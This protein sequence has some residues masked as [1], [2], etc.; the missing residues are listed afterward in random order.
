MLI[1]F[2][3]ADQSACDLTKKTDVNSVLLF[4]ITLNECTLRNKSH[5]KLLYLL[6]VSNYSWYLEVI[7]TSVSDCSQFSCYNI[8]NLLSARVGF[9]LQFTK[10]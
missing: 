9:F 3:I 4:N 1:C 8:D 10:E 2:L 7:F 6:R 5:N